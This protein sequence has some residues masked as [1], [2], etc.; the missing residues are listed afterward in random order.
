MRK[1]FIDTAASRIV[2][3]LY[4]DGKIIYEINEMNDNQL[5]VRIFPM[6]DAMFQETNIDVNEIDEINVV[7]G[8]GS[9][10]GIRI[11]VT[12][13]KTYAWALH[14]RIKVISELQWMSSTPVETEFI[15]PMIDARRKS[16]YAGVY[17][18]NLNTV[19]EDQ[20]I[21]IEELKHQVNA[22]NGTV[23]FVS[24]DE[25]NGVKVEIPEPNLLRVIEKND[26]KESLNPHAVKPEYLKKTEAEEN[27]ERA[28]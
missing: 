24:Y 4:E 21:T 7:N 16:V 9:F 8:P 26:T 22:L 13:A 20:Y 27:L 1:L 10:T 25:I 15:V 14:K 3:G 2:L 6:I 11:G 23:T 18:G 12:I 17:D 5:S 28:V 19:I